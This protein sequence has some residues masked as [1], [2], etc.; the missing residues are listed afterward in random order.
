MN[1]WNHLN[2]RFTILKVLDIWNNIP[3]SNID[4]EN[5][6]LQ[7]SEGAVNCSG[8]PFLQQS[9]PAS[10]PFLHTQC[11]RPWVVCMNC[12]TRG[13]VEH[14]G[15]KPTCVTSRVTLMVMYYLWSTTTITTL[16]SSFV[17]RCLVILPWWVTWITDTRHLLGLWLHH[18]NQDNP[19]GLVQML[20]QQ[21]N[22]SSTTCPHNPTRMDISTLPCPPVVVGGRQGLMHSHSH[23]MMTTSP[24]SHPAHTFSRAT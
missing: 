5:W 12:R 23:P 15:N 17:R 1:S 19:S 6:V 9:M 16:L 22:E 21:L 18:A 10:L 20:R 3:I 8:F 2:W 24:R 14:H 7:E 13:K 11:R 4:L